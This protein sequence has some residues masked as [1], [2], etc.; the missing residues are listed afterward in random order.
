MAFA[1]LFV[2]I[3]FTALLSGIFGMAGGLILMGVFT[4]LLPVSAAMT[5]H[6][7][8]QL[9]ANGGRVIIHWRHIKWRTIRFYIIGSVSVAAAIILIR[10]APSKA[11]VYL[12]LGLA[13]LASW[14]PKSWVQL[15]AGHP[16]QAV[17]CGLLVTGM[18][19]LSGSSGSL[20]DLFFI[21]TDLDRHTIVATKAATQSLAHIAKIAFYGAP[22]LQAGGAGLPPWWFF[23]LMIPIS[24]AGTATGGLILARFS[25]AQFKSVTR[26]LVTA[27]GIVYLCT[28]ARLF[29][30][31]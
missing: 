21:R 29:L 5:T 26:W 24:L 2:A 25:D 31:Q 23:A 17:V 3:F 20:L 19:M 6:G 7:F 12:L 1:G 4:A 13:P 30:N 14:T 11:W 22:L 15:D 16:P 10:Y 9:M 27:I 18:N 28:A 8:V